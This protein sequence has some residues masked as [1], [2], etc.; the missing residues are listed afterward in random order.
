MNSKKCLLVLMPLL[1]TAC[2]TGKSVSSLANP[3]EDS[4]SSSEFLSSNNDAT[5]SNAA[6]SSGSQTSSSKTE[7]PYSFEAD[8]VELPADKSDTNLGL[9][10]NMTS[11]SPFDI[12]DDSL[13]MGNVVFDRDWR[14]AQCN[15]RKF[16]YVSKDHKP[17]F[18]HESKA[19]DYEHIYY[20]TNKNIHFNRTNYD[21]P[22]TN[23]RHA[24]KVSMAYDK[25]DG[26]TTLAFYSKATA[27]YFSLSLGEIAFRREEF[28]NHLDDYFVSEVNK[29]CSSDDPKQIYDLFDHFGTHILWGGNYGAASFCRYY[30]TSSTHDL[31]L[32]NSS[33]KSALIGAVSAGIYSKT[34]EEYQNRVDF[35]LKML[36]EKVNPSKECFA[37]DNIDE[38][39]VAGPTSAFLPK[40]T[41]HG[42]FAQHAASVVKIFETESNNAQLVQFS[43]VYGIWD[44][45]PNSMEEQYYKLMT[46]YNNYVNYK[47]E[48][49]NKY[50]E[51]LF[52]SK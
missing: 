43:E 9:A 6:T 20:S 2:G 49:S 12:T 4:S 40:T 22:A 47:E 8:A 31:G 11:Y 26:D 44:F 37:C 23:L 5:S 1:L 41:F 24:L 18:L 27:N 17:V 51:E 38:R 45:L 7:T 46:G 19:F 16:E 52:A 14:E 29:A 21:A 42:L 48:L 50:V 28:A 34:Y 3:S 13:I 32:Y 30:A 33:I 39:G 10:F 25:R 35:N 36:I 15:A